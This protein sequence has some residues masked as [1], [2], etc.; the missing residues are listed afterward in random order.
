[1]DAL[2]TIFGW[3]IFT[4]LPGYFIGQKYGVAEGFITFEVLLALCVICHSLG[5][6]QAKIK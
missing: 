4:A 6:I 5:E 2:R 1:M 3:G